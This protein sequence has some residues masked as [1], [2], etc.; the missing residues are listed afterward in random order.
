MTKL[1]RT[2]I[3]KGDGNRPKTTYTNTIHGIFGPL[4]PA[5]RKYVPKILAKSWTTPNGT[6]RTGIKKKIETM[7]LNICLRV[8]WDVGIRMKR[9]PRGYAIRKQEMSW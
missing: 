5:A 7:T 6:R 1:D 4:I 3:S 9:L 8:G 2:P